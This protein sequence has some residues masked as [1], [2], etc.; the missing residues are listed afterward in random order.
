L[1]RLERVG[2]LLAVPYKVE[3][4]GEKFCVVK[5]ADGKT[6]ACHDSK[7][8]AEAQIAA[9]AASEA[10]KK[11]AEEWA[12]AHGIPAGEVRTVEIQGGGS[13]RGEILPEIKTQADGSLEV[14]ML[15]ATT[16]PVR[17][18]AFVDGRMEE[19]D[20]VLS[21]APGAHRDARLLSGRMPFL[22]CHDQWSLDAVLGVCSDPRWDVERGE[23]RVRARVSSRKDLEGL[24]ED[25]KARILTNTSLGYRV[26]LYRDVTPR[27][28]VQPGI[29]SDDPAQA[30]AVRRLEAVDWESREASLVPVGADWET[31]TR[32]AERPPGG[33]TLAVP[34]LS[35]HYENPMPPPPDPKPESSTATVP[36]PPPPAAETRQAQP[37]PASAAAPPAGTVAPD[38]TRE[39]AGEL[40]LVRQRTIRDKLTKARLPLE[41]R[42][43]T[44]LLDKRVPLAQAT[45]RILDE[46]TRRDG[47]T[48]GSGTIPPGESEEDKTIRAIQDV[49][50]WR[51]LPPGLHT[52][53]ERK[54]LQ[55]RLQGNPFVHRRL[56]DIGERYLVGVHGMRGLDRLAPLE[57]AHEILFRR[58]DPATATRGTPAFHVTSDFASVLA[59]VANKGLQRQFELTRDTFSQWTVP[60]T[61]PDF[62][63][64]KRVNLGDAPRLL[65]KLEG[66]EIKVGAVGEKGENVQLLTYARA[67]NISRESIINDDLG[68]FTRFPR[69]FGSSSKQLIA[70]LV[71]SVLTANAALGDGFALFDFTNHGNYV[72]GAGNAFTGANAVQAISNVRALARKQKGIPPGSPNLETPFFMS[73]DLVH[74]RVP[75]NLETVA[76]QITAA[77]TPQQVGNVNPFQG[78]FASVMAEPR[79]GAVSQ[80]AF[81]LMAD[82]ASVDTIEVDYL[83]GESGP[84]IES[85]MSWAAEG[86]EMKCRLDVGVAPTEYRG[87][88][89]NDG[90]T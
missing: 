52:P 61:L 86:V 67:V 39:D 29:A 76:Q 11:R 82:P 12:S 71:Y 75:E 32:S 6:V 30:R 77:L 15:L 2:T 48:T 59:N 62:K 33:E 79:L 23:M 19:I 20:E 68:A 66:A 90:T 84:V 88:Y 36:P 89:K 42:L 37:A 35:A 45:D 34:A 65:R 83:Q 22:A 87:L 73:L 57:L 43:A 40:E 53:E 25:V 18:I 85:R 38:Q 60:G 16:K 81:Y 17:R 31:S 44:E 69:A 7:A 3:K 27:A 46:V 58:R 28:P 55:K 80:I 78:Q 49:L 26:F 51:G 24:R 41:G 5:I 50:E 64:A 54:E 8:K 13:I 72:T 74:L 14:D 9:I 56:L 1:I 63:Q 21:F 47:E 10:G 4:Q 70:D